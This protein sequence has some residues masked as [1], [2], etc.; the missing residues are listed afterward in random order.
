MHHFTRRSRGGG[1]RGENCNGSIAPSWN[2]TPFATD[3]VSN[4][5]VL[6]LLWTVVE[7]ESVNFTK[8]S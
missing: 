6:D 5:F 2:G 7:I 4:A 8:R 3:S 1:E